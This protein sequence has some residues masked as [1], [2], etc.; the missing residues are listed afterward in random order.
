MMAVL[1]SVIGTP[2][3]CR[4]PLQIPVC[5]GA[6]PPAAPQNYLLFT[7]FAAQGRGGIDKQTQDHGAIVTGELDEVGLGDE[8]AEF[9]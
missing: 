3:R 5:K 1:L 8:T 4:R 7:R 2:Y 6:P 9:D